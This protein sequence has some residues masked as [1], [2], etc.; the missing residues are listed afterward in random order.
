MIPRYTIGCWILLFFSPGY[1]HVLAKVVRV[2]RGLDATL[3]C[4]SKTTFKPTWE[5]NVKP[6]SN[7][8]TL[9]LESTAYLLVEKF[10]ETNEGLYYCVNETDKKSG[11]KLERQKGVKNRTHE[12]FR[13]PK[14]GP[15]QLFCEAQSGAKLEGFWRRE[16]TASEGDSCKRHGT[17]L[18][19]FENRS[20]VKNWPDNKF[21][22]RISPLLW[23]DH[24]HYRCVLC[25][26][27]SIDKTCTYEIITVDVYQEPAELMEG[28]NGSVVCK[29][30]HARQ[31]TKLLWIEVESQQKFASADG[32][33]IE[34]ALSVIN[35]TLKRSAWV[36]AVFYKDRLRALLPLNLT[37]KRQGEVLK[38]P[39][40]KMR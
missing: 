17:D 21:E 25:K 19:L 22:L 36:C 20:E 40:M 12:V 29:V 14:T 5:W 3:R 30:S 8:Q 2:A 35:V 28:G 33:G 31:G 32:F 27:R 15:L 39:R 24:G 16:P 4:T 1:Y 11:V 7:I 38:E 10:Q 9:V 26:N 6:G 13:R 18:A 34:F 37:I 23:E